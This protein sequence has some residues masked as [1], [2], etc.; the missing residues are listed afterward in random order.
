MLMKAIVVPAGDGASGAAS[1]QGRDRVLR[2][3]KRVGEDDSPLVRAA[4]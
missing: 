2:P 3:Y 4:R 1:R